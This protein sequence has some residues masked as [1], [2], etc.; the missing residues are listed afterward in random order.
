MPKKIINS[1]CGKKTAAGWMLPED[2]WFCPARCL[3][4]FFSVWIQRFFFGADDNHNCTQSVDLSEGFDQTLF[5][6]PWKGLLAFHTIPV[7]RGRA[8]MLADWGTPCEAEQEAHRQQNAEGKEVDDQGLQG[9]NTKKCLREATGGG[10]A[11]HEPELQSP[12]LWRNSSC[13]LSFLAA[14]IARMSWHDIR[15]LV[16]SNVTF[17]IFCKS[18][19]KDKDHFW[20]LKRKAPLIS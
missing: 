19:G 20:G 1:I 4:C 5:T 10:A 13:L 3:A 16:M 14:P 2:A 9:S 17:Q 7:V 11:R 6:L 18:S 15:D 12:L 8:R